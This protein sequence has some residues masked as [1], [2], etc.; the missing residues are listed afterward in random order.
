VAVASGEFAQDFFIRAGLDHGIELGQS[1]RWV[2]ACAWRFPGD[3]EYAT[4][5]GR[6]NRRVATAEAVPP[7][8]GNVAVQ[9][10]DSV[11]VGAG[12]AS[13]RDRRRGA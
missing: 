3:L 5:P 11:E 10:R 13:A 7:G 6:R 1:V 2:H 12:D 8:S 9:Q 4:G